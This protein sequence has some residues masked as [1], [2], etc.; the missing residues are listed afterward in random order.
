[1][2]EEGGAQLK[3]LKSLVKGKWVCADATLGGMLIARSDT[4]GKWVGI[5]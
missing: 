2:P 4:I 1:L 5:F 3:A